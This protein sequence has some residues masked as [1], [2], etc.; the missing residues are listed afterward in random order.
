[1]FLCS[2]FIGVLFELLNQNEKT[3]VKRKVKKALE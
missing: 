3:G 2:L 1:M